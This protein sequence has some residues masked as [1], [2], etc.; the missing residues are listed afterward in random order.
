MFDPAAVAL[1]ALQT[2][3]VNLPDVGPAQLA[4]AVLVPNVDGDPPTHAVVTYW[5]DVGTLQSAMPVLLPRLEMEPGEQA[6]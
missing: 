3:E 5:P 4:M 2:A 1:P 6:S